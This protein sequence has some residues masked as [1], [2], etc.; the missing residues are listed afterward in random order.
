MN[1]LTIRAAVAVIALSAL[2]AAT[3]SAATV[4]R[5]DARPARLEYRYFGQGAYVIVT[6]SRAVE[7]PYALTGRPRGEHPWA[8]QAGRVIETGQGRYIVPASR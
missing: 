4:G 3:V 8:A 2:P 6:P 5:E 1:R 7:A